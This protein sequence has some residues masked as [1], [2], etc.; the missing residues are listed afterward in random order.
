MPASFEKAARLNPWNRTPTTPPEMPCALNAPETMAANAAGTS[1]A[2][3]RMIADTSDCSVGTF[4]GVHQKSR[5]V[6]LLL[7]PF[8]TGLEAFHE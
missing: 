2:L 4:Y 3:M 8:R 6:V 5:H 1:D 7:D